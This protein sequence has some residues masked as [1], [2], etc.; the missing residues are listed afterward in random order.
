MGECIDGALDGLL[1]LRRIGRRGLQISNRI[2]GEFADNIAGRF[3]QGRR[4][5]DGHSDGADGRTGA[6][7]AQQQAAP[8][9]SQGRDQGNKDLLA[10]IE[11][12][13]VHITGQFEDLAIHA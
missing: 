8:P 13:G 4:G 5:S 7:I 11:R 1:L 3:D 12:I 6:L 9:G 10:L 2:G